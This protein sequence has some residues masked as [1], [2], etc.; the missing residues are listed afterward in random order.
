MPTSCRP[1]DKYASR[2]R[3]RALLPILQRAWPVLPEPSSRSRWSYEQDMTLARYFADGL[4]AIEVAAAL[5]LVV[6]PCATAGACERRIKLLCDRH[7]EPSRPSELP[8][9]DQPPGN[10]RS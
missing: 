7:G 9:Q 1:I 6:R 10:R 4:S 5:R 3:A 2:R 8:R